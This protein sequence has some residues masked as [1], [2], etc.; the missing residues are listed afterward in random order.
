MVSGRVLVGRFD[1]HLPK[2]WEW[3]RRGFRP[4]WPTEGARTTDNIER[5]GPRT[6]TVSDWE[7]PHTPVLVDGE[8]AECVVEHT[9]QNPQDKMR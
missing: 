6:I 7:D 3:S 2:S 5:D 9:V 8:M 4:G 1:F